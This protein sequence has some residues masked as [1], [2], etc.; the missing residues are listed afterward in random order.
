MDERRVRR[1]QDPHCP[2]VG[3]HNSLNKWRRRFVVS[4]LDGLVDKPRPGRPSSILLDKIEGVLVATLEQKPA[5]AMHRSRTST[6]ARS[7]F[8]PTTIGRIWRRFDLKI[9]SGQWVQTLD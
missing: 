3:W 6:A 9:P 7:G 1:G 2:R 5:N 4:R 8:S